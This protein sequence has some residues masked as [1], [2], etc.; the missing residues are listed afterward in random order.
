MSVWLSLHV[1][2]CVLEENDSHTA[3]EKLSKA[4]HDGIE[5]EWLVDGLLI[6][7]AHPNEEKKA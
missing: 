5:D 6:Y 4:L 1:H 7:E 3:A 2:V